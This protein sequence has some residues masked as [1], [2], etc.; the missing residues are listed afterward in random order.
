VVFRVLIFRLCEENAS[1]K[2]HRILGCFNFQD[3]HLV[4]NSL[5]MRK[6]GF[7]AIL[8]LVLAC[9]F[10]RGG[11]HLVST[12]LQETSA[13]I[14]DP[15]APTL[16][17]PA[18]ST[19]FT[20]VPI[21][22]N[23]ILIEGFPYQ[24]FQDPAEPFRF[25]CPSPCTIDPELIYAQYAGFRGA[26]ENLI[27]LTGA[28]NLPEVQPVDIHIQNDQ[29][30]GMFSEMR[31]IAYTNYDSNFHA[32]ICSFIFEYSL[33][34]G[35]LP[36]TPADAIR[37][38]RQGILIHEYAH[39]IFYGRMPR[40]VSAFHDFVTPL[41]LY[42]WDKNP[43]GDY[44]CN[45]RPQTPPGDFDGFLIL[46]LC[47]QNGFR[48]DHVAP[49]LTALDELYRS[50]GGQ[51]DD[52]FQQLTPSMAQFREILNRILGS[53]TSQ[54]F[55]DACWPGKIFGEDYILPATCTDRTPMPSPTSL[56]G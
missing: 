31:N 55:K 2:N 25:V 32:F 50:G 27:H 45:Y 36:Y 6:F 49:I 9:N 48:D 22:M 11:L 44:L 43:G 20:I 52:G 14:V 40:L 37:L 13:G 46:E 1:F 33:G 24:A 10:P 39:S 12:E 35:G 47:K 42:A 7:G 8:F 54:A 15:T 18:T 3:S 29:K 53:D 28:D 38:D 51:V 16:G 17:D 4:Y 30:C 21:P 56:S 41:G 5:L 19:P 26:H 34:A 23:E